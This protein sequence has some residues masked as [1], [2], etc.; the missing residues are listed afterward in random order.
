MVHMQENIIQS[1][2]FLDSEKQRWYVQRMRR[3]AA[4]LRHLIHT[5]ISHRC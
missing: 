2:I 3:N 5:K 1:K 4:V